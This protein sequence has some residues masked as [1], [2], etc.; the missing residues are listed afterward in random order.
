[1]CYG[2]LGMAWFLEMFPVAIVLAYPAWTIYVYKEKKGY[3]GKELMVKLL[4]PTDSWYNTDRGTGD[5]PV[6]TNHLVDDE[7]SISY[8]SSSADSTTKKTSF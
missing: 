8:C 2:L 6:D 3:S 4:N 1:M 5:S 7:D